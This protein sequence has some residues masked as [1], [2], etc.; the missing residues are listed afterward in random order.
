MNATK[1]MGLCCLAQIKW[2]ILNL[3][4]GEKLH[5]ESKEKRQSLDST[6]KS[7]LLGKLQTYTID[8]YNTAEK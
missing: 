5:Y 6:E 1:K 8:R 2:P 3:D 4:W 7:D